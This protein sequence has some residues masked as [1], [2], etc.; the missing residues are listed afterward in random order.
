MTIRINSDEPMD[1]VDYMDVDEAV[2]ADIDYTR[3]KNLGFDD[4]EL[5]L[6]FSE[7]EHLSFDDVV[8]RYLAIANLAIENG[9]IYLMNW[10]EEQAVNANFDIPGTNFTKRD[11]VKDTL[12]YYRHDYDSDNN[13]SDNNESYIAG[14][15]KRSINK[16][17]LNKRRTKY[18]TKKRGKRNKGRKSV[19]KKNK[20]RKNKGRKSVTKKNK[21]RKSVTKKNKGRKYV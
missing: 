16:R 10:N 17:S 4:G 19:T 11:I 18:S 3:L 15:L 6:L 8:Q 12:E 2:E 13:E 7:N 20:G 14:G 21:G 1:V 5:E 9:G